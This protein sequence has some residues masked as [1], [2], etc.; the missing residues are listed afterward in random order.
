M[1][2]PKANKLDSVSESSEFDSELFYLDHDMYRLRPHPTR[3]LGV[4]SRKAHLY[5]LRMILILSNTTRLSMLPKLVRSD[6]FLLKFYIL[7]SFFQQRHYG[8]TLASVTYSC[9]LLL[10]ISLLNTQLIWLL[11]CRL[12]CRL[13]LTMKIQQLKRQQPVVMFMRILLMATQHKFVAKLYVFCRSSTTHAI[14]F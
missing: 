14:C 13:P 2:S 3:S 8:R 1:S 4:R 5:I 11:L 9:F 7:L 12:P 6:P 10:N